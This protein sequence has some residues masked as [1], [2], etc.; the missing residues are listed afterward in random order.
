MLLLGEKILVWVMLRNLF[1]R[2]FRQKLA[3]PGIDP[4]DKY[5]HMQEQGVRILRSVNDPRDL[6]KIEG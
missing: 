3:A 1:D 4:F 2:V 6:N 5:F